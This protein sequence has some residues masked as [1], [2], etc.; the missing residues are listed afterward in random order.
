MFLDMACFMLGHPEEVAMEV[1]NSNGDCGSSSWSFRLLIDKCLVKVDAEGRL[2]MHD[3][4]PDMGCDV[5]MHKL[6]MQSHIWDSS[7]AAK[8]LQKEQVRFFHMSW[9]HIFLK[10]RVSM[11][12]V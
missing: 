5:V 11:M 3:L 7:V 2:T 12:L 8:I 1:W 6:E 9:L 10:N 4:L